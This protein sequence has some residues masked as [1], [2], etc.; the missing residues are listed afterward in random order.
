MLIHITECT[1]VSYK[2]SLRRRQLGHKATAAAEVHDLDCSSLLRRR[3]QLHR[4]WILEGCT[5][6]IS[7]TGAGKEARAPRRRGCTFDAWEAAARRGSS[8]R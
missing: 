5:R 3:G 8:T 7:A 1:P 4:A 6:R 2:F